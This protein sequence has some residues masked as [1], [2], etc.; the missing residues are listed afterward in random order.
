MRSGGRATIGGLLNM[1]ATTGESAPEYIPEKSNTGKILFAIMIAAAVVT[2]G[3]G[4]YYLANP[5]Q[6]PG[7]GGGTGGKTTISVWEAFTT[8]E[9][10]AFLTV[11][12]AFMKAYP[13]ITVN[14]V[15]Q[16]SASPS[17]L[18]PAAIAGNAPNIIIGTSDFEGST[19]Y[20]YNK[21][22]NLL[23]YLNSSDFSIYSSTALADV[24]Y[25]GTAIYAFPLNINGIAM[26]YNKK[27][28]PT[29]PQTTDQ[30]I[31]MAKNATVISGGRYVKS[32][33]IAGDQADSGYS[34]VA[35]QAGFGGSL[36]A[37]DGTPTINTTSTINAMTFLK[38]L[39]TVD[40][41]S[42]TGYTVKTTWEAQFAQGNVGI[43]FDGPWEIAIYNSALGA[44]NVGVAPMPMV[45][46]TG[47]RPL[48]FLGSIGVSVLSQKSS[49]A[50]S[51]EINASIQ[52]A[53]YLSSNASE[54]QFWNSAGDFPATSSGLQYVM[55]LNVPWANGFAQ[56]FLNYSQPFYNTPQ[57]GYYWTPF[58]TYYGG[59]IAGTSTATQA[60]TSIQN[61]IVQSMKASA[62]PVSSAVYSI[63]LVILQYGSAAQPSLQMAVVPST[64]D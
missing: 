40:R 48:P 10:P 5:S 39:T 23:D 22:L 35:W 62:M 26:I 34:F 38:N 15:Q 56:Q 11:R 42:P 29:A 32:G 12:N 54:I 64:R 52:F 53:K 20:F 4:A 2:A 44:S 45:S 58:G 9:L 61:A 24:T 1:S 47:L 27:M 21:T 14:Y 36:F 33:I 28:I 50:T 60:A 30:M 31:Q 57:M 43:V 6:A 59:F 8:S 51:E 3:L 49:S 41:V 25:N 17:T 13:N 63:P 7:G 37:T 55:S 18:L 19:M 16:Q 46:Q